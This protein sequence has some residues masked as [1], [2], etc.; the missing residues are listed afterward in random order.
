[1]RIQRL[2]RGLSTEGGQTLVMVA[3]VMLVL[4]G[5]AAMA[6]D[7]AEILWSR[8]A[9]QDAA[10]AAALAGVR[11]LPGSPD[12][13]QE[14]ALRYAK[15]NGFDDAD[16]RV[17]VTT[18]VFTKFNT[19]DSLEVTITRVVPPGLRAAVGGGNVTVPA[20]AV[21]VVTPVK[22]PCGL[23]PF[24]IEENVWPYEDYKDG[25]TT[26]VPYWQTYG[27]KVVLKVPDANT[28]G[29]FLAVQLDTSTHGGARSYEDSIKYGGC[30]PDT[31]TAS[32]TGNMVGPTD[33]GV[34]EDTT[35]LG[36]GAITSCVPCWDPVYHGRP[37]PTPA[38]DNV[39]WQVSDEYSQQYYGGPGPTTSAGFTDPTTGQPIV[40]PNT[41]QPYTTTTAFGLGCPCGA[42]SPCPCAGPPT[43]E[44]PFPAPTTSWDPKTN[45]NLCPRVGIVPILAPGSW[46]NCNGT[47][48][49]QVVGYAGFYLIGMEFADKGNQAYVVGAFLKR[50]D[51][52]G[53][54]DYGKPLNGPVGYY[55]WR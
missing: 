4:L 12:L 54:P 38:P 31:V 50:V 2:R 36:L 45:T 11:E 55:L 44:D 42:P 1:M 10:D 21:A 47:C 49:V 53:P 27:Q 25:N 29:N 20:Q 32:K 37:N 13:A 19:N 8:S 15:D 41:G 24:G 6:V 46:A 33:K 26:T 39:F 18:R 30:L 23:W 7:V 28:P 9:Q 52:V 14:V 5:L 35:N 34:E 43:Q 22:P 3:V 48:T 16:P 17:S 40:D 51:V